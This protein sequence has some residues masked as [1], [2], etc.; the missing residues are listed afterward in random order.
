MQ[1]RK[2]TIK[3]NPHILPINCKTDQKVA[4][5]EEIAQ[6]AKLV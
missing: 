6:L 1:S 3:I 2:K 4:P 5:F